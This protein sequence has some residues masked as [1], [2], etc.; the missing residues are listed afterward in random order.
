MKIALK[1][2]N[3]YWVAAEGGGGID[4]RLD[5]H[6][7]A[8]SANRTEI[9]PWETFEVEQID[10]SH[11]ALKTCDG[12]YVTAEGGGGSYVRTDS[13]EVGIWETF[14]YVQIGAT[15]S[16]VTCDGLHMVGVTK[17]PAVDARH[18]WQ[19]FSVQVLEGPKPVP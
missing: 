14:G 11:V 15:V 18:V 1:A 19:G 13:K 2:S 10:P 17:T 4:P 6:V 12:F 3:G 8:L 7:V 16:L 9:G 5:R